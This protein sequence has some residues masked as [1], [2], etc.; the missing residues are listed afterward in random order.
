[1]K[2]SAL[3]GSPELSKLKKSSKDNH[4]NEQWIPELLMSDE[5]DHDYMSQSVNG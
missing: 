4:D 1:M 5:V 3:H 2:D